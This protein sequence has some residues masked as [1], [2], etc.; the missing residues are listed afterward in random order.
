MA[1]AAS[2]QC[3]DDFFVECS[4]SETTTVRLG[5]FL[6]ILV[7]GWLYA[8]LMLAV[9]YAVLLL[10]HIDVGTRKRVQRETSS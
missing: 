2:Y 9:G 6:A 8:A 1:T 4:G 3:R 5:V 10:S 7:A